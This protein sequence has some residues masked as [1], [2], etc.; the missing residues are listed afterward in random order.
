MSS[1]SSRGE[2]H[3]SAD[4][5]DVLVAIHLPLESVQGM[6]AARVCDGVFA[7]KGGHK[8]IEGVSEHDAY[9][10][11]EFPCTFECLTITLEGAGGPLWTKLNEARG[12]AGSRAKILYAGKVRATDVWDAVNDEREQP[13]LSDFN[14]K[15]KCNGGVA[16]AKFTSIYKAFPRNELGYSAELKADPDKAGK[17]ARL[18]LVIDKLRFL[19]GVVFLFI[20]RHDTTK[21]ESTLWAHADVSYIARW[22]EHVNDTPGIKREWVRK[23]VAP[24]NMSKAARKK[25]D[26]AW[27]EARISQDVEDVQGPV[28]DAVDDDVAD[29]QDRDQG[30]MVG[31]VTADQD[32]VQEAVDDDEETDSGSPLKHESSRSAARAASSSRPS[33]RAPKRAPPSTPE[34]DAASSS[35]SSS[36]SPSSSSDETPAENPGIGDRHLKRLKAEC[37]QAQS[38]VRE[39]KEEIRALKARNRALVEEAEK[40]AD[41]MAR[42]IDDELDALR[43]NL[44]R[45]LKQ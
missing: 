21:D 16:P 10:G 39:L 41:A 37:A 4:S 34:H 40:R 3:R 9:P 24:W 36:S 5:G 43:K 1:S 12:G 13:F 42:K 27:L 11:T 23:L 28:Q 25:E 6:S 26:D 8:I 30:A 35:S 38:R 20:V 15:T 29:D 7:D 19:A 45:S 18:D 2:S 22:F 33:V 14:N 17:K 32:R 31:G 44:L